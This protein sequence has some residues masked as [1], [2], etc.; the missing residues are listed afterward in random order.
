MVNELLNIDNNKFAYIIKQKEKNTYTVSL[1]SKVGFN[2]AKI[3]SKFG[4]GGHEQASGFSFVGSPTKYAKQIF[5][6]CLKQTEE[7]YNV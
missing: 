1:R 3:A 7:N 6:E 5:D 4:G 2:V